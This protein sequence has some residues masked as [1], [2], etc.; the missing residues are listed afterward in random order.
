[1]PSFVSGIVTISQEIWP[2][3]IYTWSISFKR[4]SYHQI[5]AS[6]EEWSLEIFSG[7]QYFQFWAFLYMY[8]IVSSQKAILLRE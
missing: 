7:I 2:Q 4:P 8:T 3:T 1:M 6:L 5:S